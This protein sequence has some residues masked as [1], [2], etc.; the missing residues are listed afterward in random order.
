[1]IINLNELVDRISKKIEQPY[2]WF[3]HR[4][5]KKHQYNTIHTSL[6]PGYYDPDIILTVALFEKACEY[7]NEIV[8]RW[9]IGRT[10]PKEG[11]MNLNRIL[12]DSEEHQIRVF[13][14]INTFWQLRGDGIKNGMH[15]INDEDFEE[16]TEHLHLI[17]DNLKYMWY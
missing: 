3:A 10:I 2:Y 17:I 9:V 11:D 5:V 14:K 16:V 12:E 7:Y 1:M 6:K 4:F 13:S 8:S 15:T